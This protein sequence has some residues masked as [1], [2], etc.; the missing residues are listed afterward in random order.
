MTI[1]LTT[2]ELDYLIASRQQRFRPLFWRQILRIDNSIPKWA[3]RVE[4]QKVQLY[5]SVKPMGIGGQGDLPKPTIDRSNGFLTLW[6]FGCMYEIKDDEVE[7]SRKVGIDLRSTSSFANQTAA[8]QKLNA[9]AWTG[10]TTPTLPGLTTNAAAISAKTSEAAWTTAT[11]PAVMLASLNAL[12]DRVKTQ[13]KQL[14]TADTVVMPLSDYRL[15]STARLWDGTKETV[16]STFREQN[17]SVRRVV[18]IFD[19]ETAGAGGVGRIVAFDAV[20]E[21]GPKMLIAQEFED[22]MQPVRKHWG[23]EIGQS[24][25]TG[26]VLI[27]ADESIA[28]HDVG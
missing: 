19:L 17:P 5:A 24:F 2:R 4:V 6:Q 23:F 11:D 15:I 12:V 27:E 25:K 13:S 8:E 26:G 28:Y 10:H 20:A 3:L 14:F 22:E 7:Y 16:L 18:E 9:I 21:E 1:V